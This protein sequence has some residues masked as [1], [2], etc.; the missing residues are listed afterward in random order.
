MQLI[1]TRGTVALALETALPIHDPIGSLNMCRDK[2][3]RKTH[4]KAITTV[5]Q[6]VNV[7]DGA[8]AE[9]NRPH[10]GA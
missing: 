8:E 5:E 9:P 1:G 4:K 6:N 3:K 7:R 2:A 10:S